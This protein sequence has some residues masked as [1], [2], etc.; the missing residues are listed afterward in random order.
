MLGMV[1]FFRKG[2]D[3][4][5]RQGFLWFP[6]FFALGII[7]YFTLY[8]SVGYY[9]SVSAVLCSFF[10]II[11]SWRFEI[12]RLLVIGIFLFA[13][14]FLVAQLRTHSVYTPV[15]S[16][17]MQPV[18]VEGVIDYAEP[19]E[20]GKGQRLVLRDVIIE[21]LEAYD[22]PRK[23]R[24]TFRKTLDKPYRSGQ[25]I[26]FLG[27]LSPPSP[28]L[29]PGGFDFQRYLY[30]QGIGATGFSFG[31]AEVLDDTERRAFFSA[32]REA[33]GRK[34]LS[35]SAEH[36]QARSFAAAMLI[37][38]RGSMAEANREAMRKAGLAHMLA[39]S[40]LHIGLFSGVVFFLIRCALAIFPTIALNYPIKKMA[41]VV[42]MGAAVFYMF[43]A[44]ASIPSQRAV[45]MALVFYLAIILDRTPLSMRLVA[46]AAMVVLLLAPESL[47]NVS[48]QLSFSAVAALVYFYDVTSGFWKRLYGHQNPLVRIG[49]YLLGVSATTCVA[50]IA[51]APFT[52]YHFQELA[53]YGLLGNLL[54]MPVLSFIVMPF[55]VI[56]YVL[57]PLGLEQYPLWIVGFG[58][59]LI[60]KIAHFVS[61]LEGAVVNVGQWDLAV[62]LCFS[63]A[64]ILMILVRG[65]IKVL[66]IFPFIAAF[67]FIFTTS[68]PFFLV[69]SSGKLAA[70]YDGE[71]LSFSTLRAERFTR[72]VWQRSYGLAGM[73][74]NKWQK[75][76]GETV[77]CGEAG[78]R[79]RYEEHIIDIID[80]AKDF[81]ESCESGADVVIVK[82]PVNILCQGAEIINFYDLRYRGAHGL[83][84]AHGRIKVRHIEPFAPR[85]DLPK[86][87][88]IN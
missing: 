17:K 80:R 61:S 31:A 78:C 13:C 6:V 69:A 48:F 77:F 60:F 84:E 20:D 16:K 10:L 53:T 8:K 85:F 7:M 15:L 88:G 18:N 30:F 79:V 26:S 46:F 73:Q 33:I 27:G 67:W 37:G 28:S 12:M 29:I 23:I 38:E 2:V 65:W 1:E 41:A 55:A 44:G 75:E 21:R 14:G 9:G 25:R 63:A 74:S 57:M 19:L 52:L 49:F 76:G 62:L 35:N 34:V 5:A 43:M 82:E 24:V 51:T 50:T 39:I 83:Y 54:A 36:I 71:Q 68:L 40:G 42:A 66:A 87:A 81:P 72:E 3:T 4:Q 45:L 56:S 47:L 70:F 58:G 86:P 22:T 64:S 11:G 32:L 59:E